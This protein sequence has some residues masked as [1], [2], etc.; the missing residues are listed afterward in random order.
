MPK[1]KLFVAPGSCA[2]VPTIALEEIGV[3]FETELVRTASG[4]QNSPE[5][6]KINPKGKVPALLVDG[7]PLTENVAI[8]NWLNKTYPDAAL[9]PETRD[10]FE[11]SQQIADLAFFSGTVHPHVTRIAMPMKFIDDAQQSFDLVRP[12]G[13][14]AMRPVMG[15]IN[16][17]LADRAWWYGDTW[18]IIDGYLFWTWWRIGVVGFDQSPFPHLRDHGERIVKRP[19]VARAMARE[20]VH[21]EQLKEEGHYRAPR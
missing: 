5:F 15:M 14:E 7:V 11:A 12:N 13:I 3:P 17:R 19:S 21:V 9:L 8:L 1:L 10:P 2:R 16:E 4:Q 6:R 20:D 18:S